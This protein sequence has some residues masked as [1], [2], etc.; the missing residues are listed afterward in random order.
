MP[1]HPDL[2]L[3]LLIALAGLYAGTQNTLAGGGSFITF[4]ALLLVG[5]NPLAASGFSP[6]SNRVGKVMNEPPPASVFCVPA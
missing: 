4:P 5:L 6:A 1:P 3:L 2:P